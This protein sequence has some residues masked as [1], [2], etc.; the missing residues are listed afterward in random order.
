MKVGEENRLR[1]VY[2][3]LDVWGR[4]CPGGG[5]FQSEYVINSCKRNMYS[6]KSIIFVK[7]ICGLNQIFILIVYIFF[8][9]L[10]LKR[11][12]SFKE[13]FNKLVN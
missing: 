5:G 11:Y 6:V 2:V 1:N 12:Q 7:M 8:I 10:E 13:I 9:F 4:G 3:G